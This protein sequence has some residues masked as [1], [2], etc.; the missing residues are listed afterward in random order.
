M[1]CLQ[2][3]N[4]RFLKYQNLHLYFQIICIVLFNFLV[5]KVPRLGY[6]CF[7][8]KNMVLHSIKVLFRM[9]CVY[10]IVGCL[11]AFL[12]SVFV[13]TVDHAMNCSSSGFPTLCQNKFRDFT[14]AEV[15]YDLA[16]ELVLP[17]LS[18]QSFWYATANVKDEA[19]LDVSALGFLGGC[20]QRT[21]FDARVFN[22]TAFSYRGT[23]VSPLYKQFEH[24][25][26][27]M[28]E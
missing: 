14:V 3:I 1:L 2:G 6:Q 20:Y 16:I 7:P 11:V 23:A 25:K 9:H 19:R 5:R 12:L 24:G 21:F 10:D 8:L 4:G 26:Q 28:C 18:G 13:V 15:C 17:P 22:P 27:R